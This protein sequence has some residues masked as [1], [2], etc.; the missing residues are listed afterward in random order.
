[1]GMW[2]V[3]RSGEAM[4]AAIVGEGLVG[5]PVRES[6]SREEE[7]SDEVQ[8]LYSI[9]LTNCRWKMDPAGVA[10]TRC[11]PEV[12]AAASVAL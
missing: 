11:K 9:A 6:V 7:R 2:V 4:W 12:C 10:T 3:W 8:T 5:A 1:M